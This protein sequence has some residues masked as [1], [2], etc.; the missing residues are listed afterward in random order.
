MLEHLK[1]GS[2]VDDP[3]KSK[4]TVNQVGFLSMAVPTFIGFGKV[5]GWI[6]ADAIPEAAYPYITAMLGI[7]LGG[8][9]WYK[10]ASTTQRISAFTGLSFK[11]KP[12][13]STD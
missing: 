4:T 9:M 10:N 12:N 8:F 2:M 13:D 5:M 6:P 7:G 1:K 11:F 3:V